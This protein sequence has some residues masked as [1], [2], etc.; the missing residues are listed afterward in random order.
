[1]PTEEEYKDAVRQLLIAE[2]RNKELE[3]I[4][5][6]ILKYNELIYEDCKCEW[7]SLVR[8]ARERLEK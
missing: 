2:L 1:M 7:C 3:N 6:S 5:K 4:L 8:E